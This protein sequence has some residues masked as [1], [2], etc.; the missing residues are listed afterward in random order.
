V[1]RLLAYKEIFE[2]P[3]MYGYYLEDEDGYK[4]LGSY[5]MVDVTAPIPI[6]AQFAKEQGTTYRMLKLY[7]PW[8]ISSKLSN[9]TKKIYAIKIP[10]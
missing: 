10:Q 6:L 8:L 3:E 5:K 4:E 7:T 9:P 1:F 2:H